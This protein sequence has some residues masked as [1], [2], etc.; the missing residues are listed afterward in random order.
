MMTNV[1]IGAYPDLFKAAT[2][3]AGVPFGC[4][5]GSS[6]WSSQCANGQLIRTG[7]QWVRRVDRESICRFGENP[8]VVN[9]Y[10]QGDLVRAA[11][12]GYTGERPKFQFWHGTASVNHHNYT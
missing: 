1:M 7:Q 5:A 9:M 2:A 3:Y 11:Y 10:S 8:H 6:E 4:F 12:P